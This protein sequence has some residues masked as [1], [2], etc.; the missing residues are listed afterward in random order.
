MYLTTY[1]FCNFIQYYGEQ[2]SRPLDA[3]LLFCLNEKRISLA[4][5]R[6]NLDGPL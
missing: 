6:E 1:L 4:S 2:V 5:Y 3:R